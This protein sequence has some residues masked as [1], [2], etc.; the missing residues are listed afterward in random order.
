M[1]DTITVEQLGRSMRLGNR[2]Q[3]MLKSERALKNN[4]FAGFEREPL[5]LNGPLAREQDEA[6][7]T[8]SA[9]AC[10]KPV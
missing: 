10:R 9:V 2:G 8:V 4:R 1:I 5:A 3:I 6:A 7:R